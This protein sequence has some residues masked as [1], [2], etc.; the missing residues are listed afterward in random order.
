MRRILPALLTPLPNR[1]LRRVLRRLPTPCLPRVLADVRKRPPLLSPRDLPHNPATLADL[2]QRR[3]NVPHNRRLQRRIILRLVEYPIN[4]VDPARRHLP[5]AASIL[6]GRRDAR[7]RPAQQR[8]DVGRVPRAGGGILAAAAVVGD[9]GDVEDG[10][11][12]DLEGHRDVVGAGLGHAGAEE[13]AQGGLEFGDGAAGG[14]RLGGAQQGLHCWGRFAALALVGLVVRGLGIRMWKCRCRPGML[15]Q[16]RLVVRIEGLNHHRGGGEIADADVAGPS[17]CRR[18][19]VKGGDASCRVV[20]HAVDRERAA[21]RWCGIYE[22]AAV[23]QRGILQIQSFTPA[24]WQP[25][26]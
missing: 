12:A 10:G 25:T 4:R 19:V 5:P 2:P 17:P 26:L 3:N 14:V 13:V 7:P 16:S 11:R 15:H 20:L 22:E 21:I 18:G 24:E 1:P 9:D 23:F 8:V 6:H